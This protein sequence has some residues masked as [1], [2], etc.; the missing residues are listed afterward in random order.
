MEL[1]TTNERKW[2]RIAG[3]CV[4]DLFETVGPERFVE[5][6]ACS[7]F[8]GKRQDSGRISAGF[9]QDFG[10][11]FVGFWQ[12]FCNHESRSERDQLTRIRLAAGL[13][14]SISGTEMA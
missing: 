2:T 5:I 11:I 9:W 6:S 7:F 8:A 14:E 4:G 10:R 12:G 13:R 3:F 1:G